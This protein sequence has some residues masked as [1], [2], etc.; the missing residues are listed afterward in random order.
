MHIWFIW[1]R[2]PRH[3]QYQRRHR[4]GLLV[5]LVRVHQ[6]NI[7][8]VAV[9]VFKIDPGRAVDK[10]EKVSHLTGVCRIKPLFAQWPTM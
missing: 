6:S 4:R 7:H 1:D 5:Q 9:K 10:Y 3:H 2:L 8:Q